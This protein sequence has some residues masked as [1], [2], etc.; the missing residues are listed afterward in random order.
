MD[1]CETKYFPFSLSRWLILSILPGADVKDQKWISTEGSER[2]HPRR[3]IRG[4]T[5]SFISVNGEPRAQAV[6]AL[7]QRYN[8]S[9]DG[10]TDRDKEE[11][12]GDDWEIIQKHSKRD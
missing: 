7:L 2:K 10:H 9:I 3:S 11:D 4:L 8:Y 1:M 6:L 12:G 5:F